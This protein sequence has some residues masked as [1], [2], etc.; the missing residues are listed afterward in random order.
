[1]EIAGYVLT[2]DSDVN[3]KQQ[4]NQ[5]CIAS[6]YLDLVLRHSKIE[7]SKAI[8]NIVWPH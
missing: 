1:L 6:D 2:Y 3:P 5:T 8:F 4:T 7:L